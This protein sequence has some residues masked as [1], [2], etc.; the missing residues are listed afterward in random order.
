MAGKQGG[1][2]W[3]LLLI[4]IC[5]GQVS[6]SKLNVPRVLLPIFNS[7]SLNFTLEVT[8]G[9]CYRWSASRSDII[10]LTPI[11]DDQRVLCSSK[12]LISVVSREH[13]RNTAIVLA[14]EVHSSQ[15]LRCDIITDS[16][17]SLCVLTTTREVFMEEA[18]EAFE[19]RAYDAQGNEFTTLEGVEFEWTISS[20]STRSGPSVSNVLRFISFAESPYETP[21]SVKALDGTGK[22]GHIVLLEGLRTG[23]GKVTVQLPYR[24]YLHIPSVEVQLTVMSNLLI[25]PQD[26]HLLLGDA[27]M[28]HVVQVQHGHL[29]SVQ[30]PSPQYYLEVENTT[31]ATIDSATTIA[32][33]HNLGKTLV[34]LHDRNMNE[35][36]SGIRFPTA[37]LTV[38]NPAYL[39]LTILPH[40]NWAVIVGEHHEI[41]VEVYDSNDH[42]FY[43]GDKVEISLLIPAEYFEMKYI[44]SNGTYCSGTTLQPGTAQVR[45]T[46]MSVVDTDGHVHPFIPRISVQANMMIYDRISIQ[47]VEVI[48]PWDPVAK[49]KYD[50]QLKAAGG[51]GNYVWSSDNTAIAVV[52][53]SGLVHTSSEGYVEILAAM[54][55][56]RN[57]FGVSRF[58]ILTPQNLEIVEHIMEAEVGS[59]IFLH[60]AM[61]AERIS[62]KEDKL[63]QSSPKENLIPFTQCD[64]IPF[65]VKISDDNFI[66]NASLHT[67][68]IG[69][70]C[71][72]VGIVATNIGTAKV[73]VSYACENDLLE[74]SVTIASYRPLRPFDPASGETVLAVGSSRLIV[75]AGGPRPW[76]GWPAEHSRKIET[77]GEHS[78]VEVEAIE[79]A[80]DQQDV[81]VYH[82]LCKQLGEAEVLLTVTNKPMVK[83]CIQ[84]VSTAYVRVYCAKPRYLSLEPKLSLPEEAVCPINFNPER[85]VAQNYRDI[86]VYVIVKDEHGREFD[87]ITSLQIDWLLSDNSLVSILEPDSSIAEVKEEG[88]IFLPLRH[89]QVFQPKMK[90]GVLEIVATVVGYQMKF[91]RDREVVPEY[92]PFAILDDKGYEVTPEITST[93]SLIL[94][95]DTIITPNRTSL[96]NHPSNKASLY[97]EQGSGYY[98]FVL[99][100]DDVAEVHYKE[101]SRVIEVIPKADGILK[102]ALVDL[103]LLSKPAVAEIQVIGVGTI[104]VDVPERVEKGR[105]VPA[106]VHLYDAMDNVLPVPD[107]SLLDLRPLLE[108]GLISVKMQYDRDLLSQA[109]LA[110]EVHFVVTGLELGDKRL[111]F[112]AGRGDREVRS[113]PVPIQVFPPLRLLPRNVTLVVGSVFQVSCHGGPQPEPNIEYHIDGQPIAKVNKKG[114]VSGLAIGEAKLVAL[115]VGFKKAKSQRVVYAEDMVFVKVV[116]L[117]GIKIHAPL[118]RIINGATMPVYAQ[119]IPDQLTPLVIG[120]VQSALRFS[121]SLSSQDFGVL[122]NVFYET[123]LSIA[124]T[125]LLSMRFTALKP[126]RTTIYLF[127]TVPSAMTLNENESEVEFQASLDVEVFEELRLIQPP[128]AGDTQSPY[129]LMAQNSEVQLETNHEGLLIYSLMDSSNPVYSLP[130]NSSDSG[131]QQS[132]AVGPLN[133]VVTVDQNGL[134][135]SFSATGRSVV[136]VTVK[137]EFGLKQVLGIAVEVKPIHYLMINVRADFRVMEGETLSVL[138][139]GAESLLSISYHDNTGATFTATRS[140]IKVRINRFDLVKLGRGHQKNTMVAHLMHCG[141]TML[142]VWDD[143][144]LQHAED[145]TKLTIGRVF[146]PLVTTVSLG[147]IMCF[148]VPLVSMD[149]KVGYW[150]TDNMELMKINTEFGIGRARAPGTVVIRYHLANTVTNIEVKILPVHKVKILPPKDTYITN[151]DPGALFK[152]PLVLRAELEKN[153]MNNMISRNG[154]CPPSYSVTAYPFY[155]TLQFTNPNVPFDILDVFGIHQDFDLQTGE[156]SCNIFASGDAP[157]SLSTVESNISLT[158]DSG[159]ILSAPYVIQFLPAIYVTPPEVHL[160]EAQMTGTFIIT[161]IPEVLRNVQVIPGDAMI[162][163]NTPDTTSVVNGYTYQVELSDQYWK[164]AELSKRMNVTIISS[165]TKQEIQVM[166]KIHLG[167]EKFTHSPCLVSHVS[168]WGGYISD[169]LLAYKNTLYIAGFLSICLVL[170]VYVYLMHVNPFNQ[171]T[172]NQSLIMP[173]SYVHSRTSLGTPRTPL[174]T[175]STPLPVTPNT[176]VTRQPLPDGEPVYGDPRFYC[177]GAE[178]RRN[179]RTP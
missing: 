14:E 98:E 13:V 74:D 1:L 142:K 105:C 113:Q 96:F 157:P 134:M 119:G 47:P 15:V 103:C 114:L 46:L 26:V 71:A 110:G 108:T 152:V 29:D 99:S 176:F 59:P 175:P 179:R 151:S 141:S 123:R 31:V 52:S 17:A 165:M 146:L 159:G 66:Y 88:K 156:Y 37:L 56:N 10:Q 61:L 68:P 106:V 97:V 55:S 23:T 144:T 42:K 11:E 24:E 73:T 154:T 87:N 116:P 161:G 85:M 53:Q 48:L 32:H 121:W 22:R 81:F 100:S 60:I 65:Q 118:T 128:N 35:N 171:M 135:K 79:S 172:R 57:N 174:S 83:H 140:D 69:I 33:A 92:P 78:V 104:K 75:F 115:A 25:S 54:T 149:D 80:H 109:S 167:G 95:N 127:V 50:V 120:S 70:S 132:V 21:H 43:V 129:I 9:G 173:S 94:V 2:R 34:I 18:P 117:E 82:V 7:L 111:T 16:I 58:H 131:D 20:W 148:S 168:G 72:T 147:D 126:G 166:L 143:L 51:D 133:S 130:I 124:D 170:T 45:A 44:T 40:R 125:D 162:T 169:L 41:V 137:E 112:A 8:E 89:Y 3:A 28:Y 62:V 153:K 155:C 138:P 150:S 163:V 102:I 178:L 122:N 49:P 90:S 63:S 101:G 139:L 5:L 93:L 76:I 19:V 27:I 4:F 67:N 136:V 164:T 158:V 30:M 38:S 107:P 77:G 6:N 177:G 91:L 36:G 86:N 84:S 12:A 160:S 145:Y 39:T 64:D